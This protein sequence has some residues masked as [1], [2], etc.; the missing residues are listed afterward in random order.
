MCVVGVGVA[1][2]IGG[3]GQKSEEGY[4]I[5]YRHHVHSDPLRMSCFKDWFDTVH[6]QSHLSLIL[7]QPALGPVQHIDT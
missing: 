6:L 4:C 5:H 2:I 7:C 3:K 1:N